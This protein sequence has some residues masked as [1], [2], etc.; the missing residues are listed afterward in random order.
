MFAL[1]GLDGIG[2]AKPTTASGLAL[3][4]GAALTLALY[5]V[6]LTAFCR[7]FI[8]LGR[9]RRRLEVL[10]LIALLAAVT[11]IFADRLRHDTR[12]LLADELVQAL[13]LVMLALR[14][15]VAAM[16]GFSPSRFYLVAFVPAML[17]VACADLNRHG[18]LWH[19]AD[20][21]RAFDTGIAVEA[22]FFAL[23]LADRSRALSALVGLDGLTGIANRRTFDTALMRTW[24]RARRAKGAIGVLMIDVDHFKRFN[25]AHG[26]QAGD[27]VLR[28]VARAVE[29]AVMRTDDVAARYGGEEF[30]IVLPLAEAEAAR[31]VGERVR[32]NVRD[33]AIP[34]PESE[35]GCVTVSVGV[36]SLRPGGGDSGSILADADRALYRA[37]REG[38]DR[39]VLAPLARSTPDVVLR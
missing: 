7:S 17:G 11:V 37:K 19:H 10:T 3:T 16:R 33:L 9:W 1:A 5:Y 29:D 25:D 28:Q 4:I 12:L 32:N 22:L 36:A 8:S 35:A 27:E 26:H 30:A 21:H 31:V 14:G 15:V 13:L 6:G 18:L 39:V 24:D 38:R 2:T 23:A 34:Y 20:I